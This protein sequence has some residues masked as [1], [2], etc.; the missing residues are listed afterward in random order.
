MPR[1]APLEPADAVEEFLGERKL[2]T[3]TLCCGTY[4]PYV[5]RIKTDRFGLT[6]ILAI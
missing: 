5:S 6:S 3:D 2:D 1:D 4:K